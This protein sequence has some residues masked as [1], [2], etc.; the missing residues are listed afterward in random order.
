MAAAKQDP[1]LSFQKFQVSLSFSLCVTGDLV[2][3]AGSV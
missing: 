1:F 3:V 2:G